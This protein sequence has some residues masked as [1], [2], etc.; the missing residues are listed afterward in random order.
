MSSHIVKTERPLLAWLLESLAPM[1]RSKIKQL[2]KHGQISVNGQPITQFD[3]SLQAG[4]R[5]IVV[6]WK[7][8]PDV[9]MPIIYQDRAILA[10]DKEAG[11]LSVATDEEKL[12]T[13]FA[14]LSDYLEIK[15]QGRPYV[16]HRLDR[17]T[18]GLILFARSPEARD[19]LQSTWPTV[20][21][22]YL[23]V[24]EGAPSPAQ[25]TVRNYLSERKDLLIKSHPFP[26]PEAKEA[27]THY[28]VLHTFERYS[29]VEILLET[30]RKHQIRVHL[31]GL[32]C[33]VIGDQ[34]YG[35][36]TNPANRLGL[37]AWKLA[38]THPSSG[39]V[40]ELESPFPKALNKVMGW[41]MKS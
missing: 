35:A 9:S 24:V 13:V 20:V 5:V 28:R 27:V 31:K 41:V 32:G 25:G 34:P 26:V 38:F 21:K 11:L 2:L 39:K 23:A 4:D 12:D 37:H 7:P 10:I 14:Q 17:D 1:S 3:H 19:E 8:E 6:G 33:P 15:K 18:S 29:L 16:V 40:I 36:K 30:G 22:T